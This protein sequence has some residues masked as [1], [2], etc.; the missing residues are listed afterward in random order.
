MPL[1]DELKLSKT[2]RL[3]LEEWVRTNDWGVV[4]KNLNVTDAEINSAKRVAVA[5]AARAQSE[6]A[7]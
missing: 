3:I 7:R 5:K 1:I 2:N 6:R 4:K